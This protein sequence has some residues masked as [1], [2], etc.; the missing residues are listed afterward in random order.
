[1]L[2]D[3]SIQNI[4]HQHLLSNFLSSAS[5][6]FYIICLFSKKMDKAFIQLFIYFF[7]KIKVSKKLIYFILKFQVL[8]QIL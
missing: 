3:A 2:F 4:S 7:R 8:H 5:L 6:Y 1:M